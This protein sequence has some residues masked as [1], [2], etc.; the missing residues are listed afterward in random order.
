MRAYSCSGDN[1]TSFGHNT[2]L[3]PQNLAY[4]IYTSGST[5]QSKGVM[6][7]HQS[8]VNTYLGWEQ[9]YQLRSKASCHLQMAS[10]AFDVFSGDVVRALCSGGK[11]V[12]CPKE[13]L[14]SPEQ[15]YALMLQEKVDC[16]EFVPVV[17]RHLIAYLEESQQRLD[18]MQLLICG[19]DSW[20]GGE[21][22]KFRGL[23]GEK[24]RLINSFGL[25]EA[26]IDS[27]YFE[28]PTANLPK[29]QLVPIGRPFPNTQIY[30]LDSNLQPVPI[31]VTGEL[32]ISGKGLARGYRHRPDL[33]AQ[34]FI[35]NP[36][37]NQQL[38]RLYKTG[39][40]A[41]YWADG[42]IEFLRRS[43]RQVK[44]RGFRIELG[45]IE[46]VLSQH[47]AV[48]EVVVLS[49]EETQAFTRLIAYVVP[50]KQFANC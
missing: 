4:V 31:G 23:C 17:L 27:S 47:P 15:L 49:Q 35:A 11:L 48:R 6:I 34:K 13:V 8:L 7:E 32:Y 3:P 19:S 41:R 5:G 45:E 12:L 9:I 36:F 20:Y 43:D 21:Y 2:N 24:T 14:L 29:D 33:T 38:A 40:L 22:E 25:T 1:N 44:I 50:D 18:F 37:S 26:T 10:F 16:A 28:S 39:D 46:A 30:I 42:N